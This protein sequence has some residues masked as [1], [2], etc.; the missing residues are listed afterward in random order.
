MHSLINYYN[1]QHSYRKFIF[2]SNWILDSELFEHVL[3]T[4][5]QENCCHPELFCKAVQAN[6]RMLLIVTKEKPKTHVFRKIGGLGFFLSKK[7]F[8]ER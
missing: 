8:K 5:T 4:Y 2:Y 7:C 1:Q 6:R 3:T